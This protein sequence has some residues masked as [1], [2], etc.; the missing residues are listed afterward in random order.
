MTNSPGSGPARRPS[1]DRSRRELALILILAPALT[2]LFFHFALSEMPYCRDLFHEFYPK[3]FFLAAALRQGRMPLWNPDSFMGMP[4][5]AELANACFYPLNLLF[6]FLPPVE[7]LRYYLLFHYP[8]AGVGMYLLLRDLKLRPAGAAM[9]ALSFAFCGYLVC[10]HINLIYLIS[11]TYFP[12]ALFGFRRLSLNPTLPRVLAAGAVIALPFLAGE[13]Q[14]AAL[15]ALMGITYALWN[16]RAAPAPK[17]IRGLVS[18]LGWLSAPVIF[19]LAGVMIQ[20][21]PSWEFA[22]FTER[23]AGVSLADSTCWSFYP[24]R[25]LELIWPNLWGSPWPENHFWGAFMTDWCFPLP[26]TLSLYLGLWPLLAAGYALSQPHRESHFFALLALI[27]LLFALG[28]YTPFYGLAYHL[29]PGVKLFRYPEKYLA[30]LCFA[31]AALAGIGTHS[32]LE[33]FPP[34]RRFRLV[35][36]PFLALLVLLSLAGWL[37]REALEQWLA[38]FLRQPRVGFIRPADAADRLLFALS[39][40]AAAALLLLALLEAGRVRPGRRGALPAGLFILTALDLYT[41]D[42]PLVPTAPKEIF[43]RPSPA[44]DLIRQNQV[45]PAEKFRLFRDHRADDF[46]RPAVSRR[47][48]PHLAFRLWQKNTLKHNWHMVY[49]LEEMTGYTPAMPEWIRRLG[50]KT[51]TLSLLK[52][53]NIKYLLV[54]SGWSMFDHYPEVK[55]LA[56]DPADNFRLL[57]LEGYFPRAY[58]VPQAEV[59]ATEEE[60]IERLWTMDFKQSVLLLTSERVPTGG[61]GADFAPAEIIRYEPE[62]VEVRAHSVAPAW[63]V[64]ADA[65]YPG[66]KALVN[67]KPVPIYRANYLV[68]AVAVEP[69]ENRVEFIYQPESFRQ[70][71]AITL[72]ALAL[73]VGGIG[74]RP[75][76]RRVRARRKSRGGE[77]ACNPN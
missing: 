16:P 38:D 1:G 54:V 20:F 24:L 37:G 57:L 62:R 26:W 36:L 76:V 29:V 9:G 65:Y 71:R 35:A 27:A 64:L 45:D 15:A 41:A 33:R 69:G 77:R 61:S 12:W 22:H 68:R 40:T 67:G 30:P 60:A 2:V 13:P 49:G 59:A 11:P 74:L 44:A 7:G 39:R 32:F 5:L 31:L 21:L 47:L 25:L 58:L 8:W 43:T 23:A 42:R 56:A 66:W 34:N 55:P 48:P 63:L 46:A 4:F 72:A 18:S 3:K 6:W 28:R 75:L 17:R 53:Y 19:A 73:A 70:G 14:G 51:M 10:Q 52:S 50:E